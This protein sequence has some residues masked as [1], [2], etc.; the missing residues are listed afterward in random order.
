[1]TKWDHHFV[2]LLDFS[3]DSNI[4]S[5]IALLV[6]WRKISKAINVGNWGL[7]VVPSTPP[8]I[9]LSIQGDLVKELQLAT[10]QTKTCVPDGKLYNIVTNLE[11]YGHLYTSSHFIFWCTTLASLH[12]G[13]CAKFYKLQARLL[14][15]HV[16]HCKI[17]VPFPTTV[18]KRWLGGRKRH[19]ENMLEISM[20]DCQCTGVLSV[21]LL[22]VPILANNS[23]RFSPIINYFKKNIFLKLVIQPIK[24]YHKQLVRNLEEVVLHN[25]NYTLTI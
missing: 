8:H 21:Q 17:L 5:G 2:M 9:N 16:K 14:K 7:D 4:N 24:D 25:E 18:V 10:E 1:M 12:W 22:E 15:R 3:H 11:K 6:N 19:G 13:F 20:A 23:S